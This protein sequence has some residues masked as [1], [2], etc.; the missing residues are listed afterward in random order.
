M[1]IKD[2]ARAQGWYRRNAAAPN[3]HGVWKSFVQDV[4]DT[5]QD[6]LMASKVQH[7]DVSSVHHLKSVEGSEDDI[8]IAGDYDYILQGAY[9]DD[10]LIGKKVE[11]PPEIQPEEETKKIRRRRRRR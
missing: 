5:E 1:K 11:V 6:I 7:I 4:K 3:S 2:H 9:H 8:A 10:G